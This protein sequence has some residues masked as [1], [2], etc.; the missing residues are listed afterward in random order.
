MVFHTKVTKLHKRLHNFLICLGW[1]LQVFLNLLMLEEDMEN[2]MRWKLMKG[3]PKRLKQD[4]LLHK[5]EC[6]KSKRNRKK[7]RSNY[8]V[9]KFNKKD[10]NFDC[11][12]DDLNP[13]YEE[14]LDDSLAVEFKFNPDIPHLNKN[15]E[16]ILDDSLKF[17]PDI[18]T[19]YHNMYQIYQVQHTH[20]QLQQL[21][22]LSQKQ[23]Y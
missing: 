12:S 4:V 8:K 10:S 19:T 16:E 1:S 2:Y 7:I 18:G 17:N 23:K 21:W 11:W 6:Q 5:F 22:Q 20:Q 3:T 14:I 13:N 9:D 15:N